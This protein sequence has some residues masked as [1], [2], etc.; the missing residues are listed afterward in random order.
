MH[1]LVAITCNICKILSYIY[2]YLY[3][4]FRE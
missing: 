2:V 4:K 1:T 3:M